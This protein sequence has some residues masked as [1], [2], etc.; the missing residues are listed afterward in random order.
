MPRAPAVQT[1]S[2]S[3]ASAP[4]RRQQA[5]RAAQRCRDRAQLSAAVTQRSS[6][7]QRTDMAQR[8][9][10]TVQLSAA[11]NGQLVA[12]VRQTPIATT[13]NGHSSAHG[14]SD[15]MQL[16]VAENSHSSVQQ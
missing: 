13:E 1:A 2:P 6:G 15:K 4:A 11:E 3:N 7:Q 5:W 14:N 9:S 10:D 12:A 8:S 16:T